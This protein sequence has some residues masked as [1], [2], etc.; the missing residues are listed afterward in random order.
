MRAETRP[1]GESANESWSTEHLC[2]ILVQCEVSFQNLYMSALRRTFPELINLLARSLWCSKLHVSPS[3]H[4]L[5]S[6]YSQDH[7]VYSP[8]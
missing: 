3:R 7:E 1:S 6:K 4:Q 2:H 5:G 8:K